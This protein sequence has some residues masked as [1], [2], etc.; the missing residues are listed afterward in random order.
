MKSNKSTSNRFVNDKIVTY[1]MA[2][3]NGPLIVVSFP[4]A[5]VLP[6]A[7]R[8]GYIDSSETWRK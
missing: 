8:T 2:A 7:F 3:I 4:E 1:E 5:N 6:L